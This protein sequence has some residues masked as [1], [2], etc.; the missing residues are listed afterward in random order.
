MKIINGDL[1]LDKN[2]TFEESITVN[3]NIYGK[4][5]R[6][7]S[8][9]VHGIINAWNINVWNINACDINAQNIT[10]CDINAWNINVWNI[11]A[12]NITAWDIN[13]LDINAWDIIALDITACD[14]N[15]R[16]IICESR[17]KKDSN[18]KTIARIYITGKS[19][20]TQRNWELEA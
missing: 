18:N 20:F 5:G 15:A 12:Q 17:K 10:A 8:L 16:D 2:T 6:G 1:I 14:I 3:G 7:S 4:G 9:T 11:N 19:K 13:A